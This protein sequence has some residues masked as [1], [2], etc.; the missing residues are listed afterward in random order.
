MSTVEIIGPMSRG[1]TFHVHAEGCAD[2]ARNREYRDI[3]PYLW[4]IETP[5]TLRLLVEDIFSDFIFSNDEEPWET[6]VS[7]VKVFPC[8]GALPYDEAEVTP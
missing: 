8:V 4:I 3:R 5:A 2:I 6:Y 1:T 7:E